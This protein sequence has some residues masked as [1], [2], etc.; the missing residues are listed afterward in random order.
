MNDVK[1]IKGAISSELAKYLA[2]Q[3]DLFMDYV[4]QPKDHHELVSKAVGWYSPVF[5]ESLLIYLHPLIQKHS[6]K[7]LWPTYSYGRIYYN[8]GAMARHTDRA[9][10]EYAVSL[11]LG[12]DIK[13]PLYFERTPG[14]IRKYELNPGDLVLYHGIQW[15]HWREKYK[16]KKHIQA[17][18]CYV[19][20][21]GPYRERKMDGRKGLM[22]QAPNDN[23]LYATLP[24]EIKN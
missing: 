10:G 24:N 14:N 7:E 13:Y 12:K 15:P 5:L 3:M 16:G 6:G 9:S 23:F 21:H 11:C 2:L 18:L 1:V 20:K 8:G 17:F 19:D 4:G 22:Q